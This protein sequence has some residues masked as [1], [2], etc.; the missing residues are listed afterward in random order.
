MMETMVLP[1]DIHETSTLKLEKEDNDELGS[2]ILTIPSNTCVHE[3]SSKSIFLSTT[4]TFKIYNSFMLLVHKNSEREV[5][6]AFVYH[7]HCKSR[8][9]L[10]WLFAVRSTKVGI[11]GETTSPTWCNLCLTSMDLMKLLVL[12]VCCHQQSPYTWCSLYFR[13]SAHT[14]HQVWEGRSTLISP[15]HDDWTCQGV[16]HYDTV[17]HAKSYAPTATFGHQG[18]GPKNSQT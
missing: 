10:V 11:E 17:Q 9:G 5:V 3:K 7:K 15:C 18:D 1:I 8:S 6:D 16:V 2:Y 12:L 4:V 14:L 13:E